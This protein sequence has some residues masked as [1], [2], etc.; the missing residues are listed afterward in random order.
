MIFWA[1]HQKLRQQKQKKNQQTKK[2]LD[3]EETNQ[4][5]KN[6]AYRLGENVYKP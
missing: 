6:V 1:S 4:K 2:L 5:N 3:S